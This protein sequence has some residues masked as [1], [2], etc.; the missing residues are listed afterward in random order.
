MFHKENGDDYFRSMVEMAESLFGDDVE[1][2]SSQD[3]R[4]KMEA[5]EST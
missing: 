3:E 2:L 1:E 4:R 5:T